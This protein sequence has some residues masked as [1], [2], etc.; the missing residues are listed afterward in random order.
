MKIT[1]SE[2]KKIINEEIQ[3]AV[4]TR[5]ID[6]TKY[7]NLSESIILEELKR[8]FQTLSEA[9]TTSFSSKFISIIVN[10]FLKC[11]E[12]A[13]RGNLKVGSLINNII[14]Y[15]ENQSPSVSEGI[16]KK[17]SNI[18]KALLTIASVVLA[19]TMMAAFAN[20]AKADI[21]VGSNTFRAYD[22]KGQALKG[23]LATLK[24]MSQKKGDV[25]VAKECDRLI[26]YINHTKTFKVDTQS[27]EMIVS[28]FLRSVASLDIIK[29]YLGSDPLWSDVLQELVKAGEQT[30][31]K[32]EQDFGQIR[33]EDAQYVE[34]SEKHKDYSGSGT[35]KSAEDAGKTFVARSI[36]PDDQLDL[37]RPDLSG[38]PNYAF[39]KNKNTRLASRK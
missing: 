21:K 1:K 5:S 10:T 27:R 18:R 35:T 20:V 39:L 30:S 36:Y 12:L 9:D 4:L 6:F 34:P 29:Q 24:D 2:L 22:E 31:K 26:E 17:K 14:S 25:E 11:F 19:N 8:D 16:D 13:A 32:V 33:F 28:I 3:N 23:V 15:I 37:T 38:K 7:D